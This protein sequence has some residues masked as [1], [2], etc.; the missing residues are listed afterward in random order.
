MR[1]R[2]CVCVCFCVRIYVYA[3]ACAQASSQRMQIYMTNIHF[4]Q[5]RRRIPPCELTRDLVNNI[6]LYFGIGKADY[7]EACDCLCGK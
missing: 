1:A 4:A 2:T 5:L 7:T 3:R 6:I